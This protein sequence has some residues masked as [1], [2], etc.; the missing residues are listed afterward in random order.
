MPHGVD[1]FVTTAAR[2]LRTALLFLPLAMHAVYVRLLR[3]P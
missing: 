2:A 3:N 1:R